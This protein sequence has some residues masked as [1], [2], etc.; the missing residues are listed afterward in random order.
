MLAIFS[1]SLFCF[2]FRKLRLFSWKTQ[3]TGI[4]GNFSENVHSAQKH[5][6]IEADNNAK[7]KKG[8][9]WKQQKKLDRWVA[10]TRGIPG[11][12]NFLLGRILLELMNWKTSRPFRSLSWHFR[13][14]IF[15]RGI[16]LWKFV[17]TK[18]C[19][20]K[21]E[22]TG[23]SKLKTKTWR[24][25]RCKGYLFWFSLCFSQ[26]CRK[27][28]PTYGDTEWLRWMRLEVFNQ[29]HLASSSSFSFFPDGEIPSC[30]CNYMFFAMLVGFQGTCSS[31]CLTWLL[32]FAHG[33][34]G[35]GRI[36]GQ[37][38]SRS[39]LV[40]SSGSNPF[41]HLVKGQK[42]CV[43][44]RDPLP[45]FLAS[46]WIVLHV[47][48]QEVVHPGIICAPSETA[49][50]LYISCG[51]D[52]LIEIKYV[53]FASVQN[54]GTCDTKE[55]VDIVH[56]LPES[57][58]RHHIPEDPV[59]REIFHRC[60]CVRVFACFVVVVFCFLFFFSGVMILKCQEW[61]WEFKKDFCGN[62]WSKKS[63]EIGDHLAPARLYTPLRQNFRDDALHTS[64]SNGNKPVCLQVSREARLSHWDGLGAFF[65]YLQL[66]QHS[67]NHKCIAFHPR[68][69]SRYIPF[70]W[71]YFCFY[72]LVSCLQTCLG[73]RAWCGCAFS[74]SSVQL[75][76]QEK[77][78]L[79]VA[80]F[81]VVFRRNLRA[82]R[83]TAFWCGF[84]S[85]FSRVH[86]KGKACLFQLW[87]IRQWRFYLWRNP[88]SFQDSS[89]KFSTHIIL[90]TR[91]GWMTP[92]P[93]QYHL[94]GWSR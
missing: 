16:R 92:T 78:N 79:C 89:C 7:G 70:Q 43:S 93:A 21:T 62:W 74:D 50:N 63:P 24:V 71:L 14:H 55:L 40:W 77:Q 59:G 37:L 23:Q 39:V 75:R 20:D 81:L 60:V 87:M 35:C 3:F 72:V 57:C 49:H 17:K 28:R 12:L 85:E 80:V 47:S 6:L 51:R 56:Q 29:I 88:Q 84:S 94:K 48:G 42:R 73:V 22:E 15:S 2:L 34:K 45:S 83:A 54:T 65:F 25:W 53:L 86:I 91:M 36:R 58:K 52:E 69:F 30:P 10:V 9:H 41:G 11:I 32:S 76:F 27:V 13:G 33:G 4:C 26:C 67:D 44:E 82:S 31:N 38:E 64:C 8:K 46:W 5:A 19:Q 61:Q 1:S 90:V 66:Q 18:S 68:L